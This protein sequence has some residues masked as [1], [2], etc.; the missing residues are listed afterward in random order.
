LRDPIR[1]PD[2]CHIKVY[3]HGDRYNGAQKKDKP[4]VH[5]PPIGI[6]PIGSHYPK[7]NDEHENKKKFG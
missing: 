1:I 7:S 3:S 6:E 5:E 4:K 2:L